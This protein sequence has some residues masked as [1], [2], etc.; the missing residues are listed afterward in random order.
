MNDLLLTCSPPEVT[1]TLNFEWTPKHFQ[2]ISLNDD[3]MQILENEVDNFTL[4]ERSS[5]TTNNTINEQLQELESLIRGT[6]LYDNTT[7]RVLFWPIIKSSSL[8]INFLWY[9]FVD[10]IGW[11]Q[12][13]LH[14]WFG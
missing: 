12:I 7:E 2:T 5:E 11:L 3:G 10:R 9:C 14:L 4:S 13:E 1:M 6:D 8:V